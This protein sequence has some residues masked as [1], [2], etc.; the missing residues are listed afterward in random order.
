MDRI[1]RPY[2]DNLN[3]AQYKAA[4]TTSGALRIIAG[5]GSGK[6]TTLISRCAYMIDEGVSPASILLVTFTNKAAKDMK[7]KAQRMSKECARINAMTIHS[8]CLDVLRKHTEEAG[9]GKEFSVLSTGEICTILKM[10]RGELKYDSL[11]YFPSDKTVANLIT[12]AKGAMRPV[13]EILNDRRNE[14]KVTDHRGL[15]IIVF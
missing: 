10:C 3:N 13:S 5:A 14:E 6:T 15:C 4:T 8:F 11:R 9:I 1:S 7:L 2:L 12:L